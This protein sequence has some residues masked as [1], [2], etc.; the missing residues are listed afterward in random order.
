MVAEAQG[1]SLGVCLWVL[2]AAIFGSACGGG[3]ADGE[4]TQAGGKAVN[5]ERGSDG[6]ESPAARAVKLADGTEIGIADCDELITRSRCTWNK[7]GAAQRKSAQFAFENSVK[8]WTK[9]AAEPATRQ[10]AEEA[11][12]SSLAGSKE[13]FA[14][15]G[16]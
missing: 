2:A 6:P 7:L 14:R 1:R 15:Q 13:A 9:L 10:A 11:C 4:S 3:E 12:T 16:C 5:G 8:T